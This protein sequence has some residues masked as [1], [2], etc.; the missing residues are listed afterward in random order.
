LT[1]QELLLPV[2]ESPDR[3]PDWTIRHGSPHDAVGGPN[4]EPPYGNDLGEAV[5][6]WWMT[7]PPEERIVQIEEYLNAPR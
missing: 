4:C 6:M 5:F 7:L 1:R 2:L 3:Q